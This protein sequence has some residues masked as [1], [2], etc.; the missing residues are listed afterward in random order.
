MR[1]NSL[2]AVVL[3][4][5][6]AVNSALSQNHPI[7]VGALFSLTGFGASAGNDDL[8]GVL[9]AQEE[10]NAA[11]GIAGNPVR[12]IT[13]DFRSDLKSTAT[14][15]LKLASVDKV[16]AI[17]GPNYP[18]FEE[19]AIPAADRL[20]VP[21]AEPAFT[22]AKGY[23]ALYALKS[24]IER[25]GSLAAQIRDCLAK[26]EW[27]GASGSVKFNKHGALDNRGQYTK[28]YTVIDGKVQE[29]KE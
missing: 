2:C 10:I 19:V 8:L 25:C 27:Q 6:Y 3:M 18:E 29:L 12:I 20:N 9:M 17:I 14:G 7:K 1:L 26:T 22:A 4:F 23:D 16:A 21:T 15:F 13:E 24:A 5:L 11:G 28:L